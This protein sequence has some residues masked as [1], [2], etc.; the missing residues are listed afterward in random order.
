M[1]LPLLPKV[2]EGQSQISQDAPERAGRYVTR[3]SG[4]R[5]PEGGAGDPVTVVAA[6]MADELNVKPGECAQQLSP[7]HFLRGFGRTK[8]NS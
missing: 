8:S 2:P 6:A 3:V 4:N 7:R 5:R 1:L